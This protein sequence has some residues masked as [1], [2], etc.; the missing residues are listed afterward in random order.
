M[1]D[2]SKFLFFDLEYN[3][4]TQKVREYGFILGE[5]Y[6]RDKNPAKLESAASK[7]KFIVG[8]NVLRH[9]APILRQY[10]SID[11]PNV[12]ALDTLMLS[13]LLFPRK[14]YHKLRKEYLHNEDDPSDPLEDA[15]L[16]K[17]LLEDCIE[18]W[19][20]YPW[21]LQYL[22]SVFEKRAWF[23]PFF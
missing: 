14:P 13:S 12:K 1:P 9:D 21:Q 3:P 5:E 4:E 16:C 19:G 11:F 10:F 2:F 6:V 23:C 20:S 17:K 22:L 15:R 18:K 7:A 8:H